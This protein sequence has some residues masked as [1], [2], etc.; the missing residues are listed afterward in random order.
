[1]KTGTVGYSRKGSV[2]AIALL[3]VAMLAAG[4]AR[5]EHPLFSLGPVNFSWLANS[6]AGGFFV[7]DA[8]F[9]AGSTAPDGSRKVSPAWVE[10][11]IK[12]ELR[13]T[14]HSDKF[15]TI[16]G[17][18]SAVAAGT[19]GTGDAGVASSTAGN[20]A[21]I[22]LEEAYLG[23]TNDLP[24]HDGDSFSLQLGRQNFVVDDGFLINGGTQNIGHR[25][26]YY[27]YPRTAFDGLGVLKINS[28]PIRADFFALRSNYDKHVASGVTDYQKTDFAGFD[29]QWFEDAPNA[30]ADG[31]INYADRAK[32]VG[33]TFF[34]VYDTSMGGYQPAGTSRQ[35]MNVVALSWGGSMV[36]KFMGSNATFYG[37][38]VREFRGSG[39]TAPDGTP[40]NQ[41]NAEA[42]FLEPGYT[43]DKMPLKPKVYYRYSHFSG[44]RSTN[45]GAT[46]AYDP[47]FYGDSA[48]R[49]GFGTY[50]LGEIVGQYDLFNTNENVH[51]I[52]ITLNP[53]FHVLDKG[54]S[55]KFDILYYHFMLD[56]PGA[57]GATSSNY[58]DELDLV[59]EYQYNTPTYIAIA[60]GVAVPEAAA[61]QMSANNGTAAGG[62]VTGLLE[63][64]VTY[65]F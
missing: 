29:T 64:Y 38:Y 44:Q 65:A 7:P 20:P 22:A 34:H 42:Y 13:G 53:S 47:M 24:F 21:Q 39:A 55:T 49:M 31:S 12:P 63:A 10:G 43:F 46:S 25:A 19:A 1:M 51:Q 30:G 33:F 5:A 17:D 58:A 60:G 32:Y 27:L 26:D 59:T 37:T 14:Y 36:P 2:A 52:G 41:V 35:D 3:G 45:G 56:Q 4:P 9:G 50:Y 40:L 11:Y 48:L 6:G 18:V 23:W 8:N 16:Y 28:N 61:Q 62:R 54:D 15:G 57:V